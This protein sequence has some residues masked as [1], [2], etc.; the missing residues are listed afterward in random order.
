[1]VLKE[2]RPQFAV[3]CKLS[4]RAL[5]PHIKYFSERTSIPAFYQVHSGEEDR[6]YDELRA[7]V[8]R[9]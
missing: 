5:S 8:V 6:A 2:K 1:M 3:E 9:G 4:D 7:R